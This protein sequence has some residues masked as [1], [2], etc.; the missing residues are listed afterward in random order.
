MNPADEALFRRCDNLVK[1]L[2]GTSRRR[3]QAQG[4]D[5][6]NTFNKLAAEG[7]LPGYGLEVGSVVG[8][9]DI[10][11]WQ[12]GAMD[13]SLPRAPATALREYVP[14]NLIYG[15]RPPIRG[16]AFPPRDG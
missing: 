15:Q 9:A 16:A 12:T 4:H 3:S 8:W 7:F 14:G 10:P 1:R 2:K 11:F 5:D 6:F 13:F